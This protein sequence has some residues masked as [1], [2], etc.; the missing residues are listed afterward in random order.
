MLL[1]ESCYVKQQEIR[2]GEKKKKAAQMLFK[3][4][5][6]HLKMLRESEQNLSEVLI[7]KAVFSISFKLNKDF[8]SGKNWSSFL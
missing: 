1:D 3:I 4:L 7:L 8:R 5:L 2:L 6:L